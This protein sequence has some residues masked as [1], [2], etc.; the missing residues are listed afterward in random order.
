MVEATPAMWWLKTNREPPVGVEVA[1][2]SRSNARSERG[3]SEI[4][5][6]KGAGVASVEGVRELLSGEATV[7]GGGEEARVQVKWV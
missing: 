2:G 4:G 5:G 6:G 7:E 1:T 3:R